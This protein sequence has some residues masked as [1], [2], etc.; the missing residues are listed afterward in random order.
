MFCSKEE[1]FAVKSDKEGSRVRRVIQAFCT[2]YEEINSGK[3]VIGR[4]VAISIDASG[5]EEGPVYVYEG[6]LS[7]SRPDGFGRVIFIE[8]KESKKADAPVVKGVVG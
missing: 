1:T 5:V 2:C 8:G 4:I 3:R 6:Q 7:R